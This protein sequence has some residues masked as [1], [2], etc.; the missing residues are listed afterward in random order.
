MS[1]ETAKTTVVIVTYESRDVIGLALDSLAPAHHASLAECVVVDNA[2]QDGTASFVTAQYPWVKLVGSRENVGY[3]RGC[4]L[5]L[6]EVSTPYV[7]FMNADVALDVCALSELVRFALAN[8]AAGL[9]APAIRE[10]RGGYQDADALP[11]PLT[12]LREAA[13]LRG[14]H[15]RVILPGAAPFRTNWICGAAMLAPTELVRELGGFD[16]RFF[17][18]FEETDL[19]VRVVKSGREVWACPSAETKH[20]GGASV[21]KVK[22]DLPDWDCLPEHFYPSRFY[23]LAKHYGLPAAVVVDLLEM[24]LHALRDLARMLTLRDRT[25]RITTRLRRPLLSFPPRVNGVN[26]SMQGY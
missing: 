21:R 12:L 9:I 6:R 8:P 13:G 3:G 23:Y 7:L 4:N 17:L 26:R 16:P 10:P 14:T 2:S 18:Y 20:L 19:C 22:S 25:L 5:G 11:T 1:T 15:K 24:A